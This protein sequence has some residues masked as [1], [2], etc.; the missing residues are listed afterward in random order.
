[1][2]YEEDYGY[3]PPPP[4]PRAQENPPYHSNFNHREWV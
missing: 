1:V 3:S 4:P 2:R